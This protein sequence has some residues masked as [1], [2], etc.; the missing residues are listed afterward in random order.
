M[1]LLDGFH[2]RVPVNLWR[3]DPS[4]QQIQMPVQHAHNTDQP[5]HAQ[6]IHAPRVLGIA[7]AY[8]LIVR[9]VE[10]EETKARQAR[11]D[12]FGQLV[13]ISPFY[14]F[15]PVQLQILNHILNLPRRHERHTRSLMHHVGQGDTHVHEMRLAQRPEAR[16]QNAQQ[17]GFV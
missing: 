5:P 13:H 10:K 6:H 15:A 2:A 7:H 8:V 11:V 17:V 1:E 12:Q 4:V 3:I 9:R 14:V 16:H